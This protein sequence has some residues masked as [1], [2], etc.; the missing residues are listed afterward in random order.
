MGAVTSEDDKD[1]GLI[2]ALPPDDPGMDICEVCDAVALPDDVSRRACGCRHK[3]IERVMMNEEP[4]V[5]HLMGEARDKH[6]VLEFVKHAHQAE[7]CPR[8]RHQ[9]KVAG[10]SVCSNGF[11][12]LLGI[13]RAR[14]AKTM[15]SVR[16]SGI[17]G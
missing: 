2:P 11:I 16:A 14:L 4:L 17:E 10:L 1:H 12:V 9:W 6:F 13:S 7:P 3:C 5:R 8:T 15:K